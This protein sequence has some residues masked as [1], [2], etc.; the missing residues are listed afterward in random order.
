MDTTPSDSQQQAPELRLHPF[1]WLFVL[2]TQL[3]HVALPLLVLLVF[4]RGEWWELAAVI[5]AIFLA[6]YSLVYSFGF[7]YRLG[8]DEL[9][10]REGIFDRT[11]RHIPYARVQNIVQRRNPLH[12]VF[13]VTELRLESAGGM[14]PEAVM[15]VIRLAEAHRIEQILRERGAEATEVAAA[16]DG[17]VP[18][19]DPEVLLSLSLPELLRLGLVTNRG[20]VLVASAFAV[21]WQLGPEDESMAR[22]LYSVAEDVIGEGARLVAGPFALLISATLTL[23]ALLFVIKLLSILMAVV[24]F[25]GFALGR[26][27]ERV[28]TEAGLLTRHTATARM[29]KIQRLL[30]GE[31][32]LARRLGRRWLSC[33]VAGGVV[34]VNEQSGARLKWLAPIATPTKIERIVAEVAPGLA[35]ERLEW[36]PLH[37]KAWARMFRAALLV[38]TGLTIPVAVMF[39]PW[40]IAFWCACALIGYIAARGEARFAAYACDGETFAYRGG[41]LTR[42]W[43]VAR[44]DRGQVVRL[45]E[46]PFD[47]RSG[48]ASVALDTAGAQ[49]QAFRLRV[50]YLGLDVARALA[51]QLAESVAQASRT[52]PHN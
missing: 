34:A 6:L 19:R 16:G 4:G 35:I 2:L 37:P 20:W 23:A 42:E 5:G 27:G 11:E 45:A 10:V 25:H 46:S 7:R 36:Q 40:A 17:T 50:P 12:R 15:N 31:S 14:K 38:V 3:R 49:I 24:S 43:T 44:L 21:M 30:F 32:W 51:R 41:W 47:R 26:L 13:G 8:V 1:S 22:L 9:V 33:E 48:M 28:R 18:A 52:P 29:E 39:G